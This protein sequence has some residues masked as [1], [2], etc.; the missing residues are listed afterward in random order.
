MRKFSNLFR[1]VTLTFSFLVAS[2]GLAF[3]DAPGINQQ[4]SVSSTGGLANASTNQA[5]NPAVISHDGRF[6]VFASSANNLVAGDTNNYADV[7][8]RDILNGTTTRVNTTTTGT[9][10][11]TGARTP[12]LSFDG[13]YVVFVTNDNLTP[14]SSGSTLK[15]YQR[16]MQNGEIKLVSSN[17]AGVVANQ[18]SDSP[19][20]SGDGR[21]IAFWSLATNLVTGIS[22][23]G[24]NTQIFVKDTITGQIRVASASATGGIS[25]GSNTPV[26]MNCDGTLLAYKTDATNI[27]AGDTNSRVDVYVISMGI[28]GDSVKNLTQGENA[29][30]GNVSMSCNGNFVGVGLNADNLGVAP[31]PTRFDRISGDIVTAGINPSVSTAVVP[32][33]SNDGRYAAYYSA[34]SGSTADTNGISDVY[35]RDMKLGSTSLQSK[36]TNYAHGNCY[37]PALSADANA[38]AYSCNQNANAAYKLTAT[39]GNTSSIIDYFFS[40][41]GNQ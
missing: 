36:N 12:A 39:E 10:G 14:N 13:K 8:L 29:N 26:A 17:A 5:I 1:V 24:G 40:K 23:A 11:P 18:S 34:G 38:V 16:N 4:V 22:P 19:V 3:A 33:L 28:S 32:V 7:F 9:Q 15:I 20:M 21:Y 6:V 31:G 30:P 37:T 25:N 2:I 27:I 41:T 35:I